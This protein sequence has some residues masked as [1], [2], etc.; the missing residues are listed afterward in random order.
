MF[1]FYFCI[2]IERKNGIIKIMKIK[3]IR[4][5]LILY[6]G[7]FITFGC[8]DAIFREIKPF[9]VYAIDSLLV[10]AFVL[11]CIYFDDKG[12]NSWKRIGS[13]FRKKKQ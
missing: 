8:F 3:Y 4:R 12:W 6:V 10:T 5:A 1:Y 11:V 9:E 13:L 2:Y 7:Y